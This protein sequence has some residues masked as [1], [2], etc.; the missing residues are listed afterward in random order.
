V[1]V[2]GYTAFNTD[3]TGIGQRVEELAPLVDVLCPMAY[4]SAYHAGIPGVPDPVA[5][6]YRVVLETVRR[7]R[8]RSRPAPVQVRPWIQDFRDYAFDRR[9]FG[10][11][12][13]R[14]QMKAALD[15][16]ATGWMLWNPGNRYTAEALDPAARRD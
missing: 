4:P 9:A 11:P 10:V 13:L 8:R 14:A 2:F 1:D 7:I 12:E 16:G 3:D 15:A 6:P 5:H